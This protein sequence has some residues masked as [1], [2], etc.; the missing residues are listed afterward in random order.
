MR[1]V[2]KP[3]SQRGRAEPL[4]QKT[5]RESPQDQVLPSDCRSVYHTGKEPV[6]ISTH[7]QGALYTKGRQ[8]SVLFPGTE[9]TQRGK[10]DT[11]Q[12]AEAQPLTAFGLLVAQ[13]SVAA[14]GVIC[15]RPIAPQGC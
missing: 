7:F 10:G 6:S 11:E 4:N 2:R 15:K 1:W 13:L 12:I 5:R 8:A 14:L 3:V 9:R